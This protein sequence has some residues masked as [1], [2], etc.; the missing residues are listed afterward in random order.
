MKIKDL[1][2]NWFEWFAGGSIFLMCAWFVLGSV[3]RVLAFVIG[4]TVSVMLATGCGE[5]E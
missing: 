1:R 4:S 3:D 5:N 2:E